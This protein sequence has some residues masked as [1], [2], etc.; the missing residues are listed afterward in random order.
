MKKHKVKFHL[1]SRTSTYGFVF[2]SS[3]ETEVQRFAAEFINIFANVD[4]DDES[5]YAVRNPLQYNAQTHKD[6]FDF[7]DAVAT[8]LPEI[9]QLKSFYNEL[10]PESL[11]VLLYN[12]DLTQ[13]VSLVISAHLEAWEENKDVD[14]TVTDIFDVYSTSFQNYTTRIAGTTRS[15]IGNPIKKQRVCRFC[16]RSHPETTF[17]KK[18][19]AISEALGN[20]NVIIY[21]ECDKCNENFGKGI[22][23]DLLTYVSLFRTM[24]GIQGKSGT[25]K[26]VGSNFK[27]QKSQDGD[28]QFD[29][30][31]FGDRPPEGDEYN[32]N[33]K[34]QDK[35][36]LQNIYRTL[37][38]FFISV[39]DDD[40]LQHFKKT[41][42]WIS[43][44][45]NA[46]T[47]P[48][49]REL[50]SYE[51]YT[52]Q[53]KIVYYIRKDDDSGK[54]YAVCMF[55]FTI[56]VFLFAIPF[57]SKDSDS[58]NEKVDWENLLEYLTHLKINRNWI[59]SDYSSMT[60]K[61]FTINLNAQV[62]K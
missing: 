33:L 58:F 47:L 40:Q 30:F 60:P 32:L 31:D 8:R 2:S 42:D 24:F 44:K 61:E 29:M 20:K 36:I 59:S 46:K 15:A 27:A 23:N 7:I 4:H 50:I 14:K 25:K 19:H 34:F 13:E 21:D 6:L 22:E 57:S 18:A 12:I 53:P 41:I 62:K 17:K 56:K 26:I 52:P 3:I 10:K 11:Y 51:M 1:K 5:N 9:Q 48:V 39:I 43:G 37:C 54:P 38:K 35:I 16:N 49:I 28:V 55:F 45:F